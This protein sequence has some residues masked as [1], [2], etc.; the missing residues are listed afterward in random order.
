MNPDVYKG[1]WGCSHCRDCPVSNRKSCSCV[2][3]NCQAADK[4]FGQLQN[5]FKYCL[6]SSKPIAAFIAESIQV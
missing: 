1:P 2:G 6:P 3:N 4:Y 5:I